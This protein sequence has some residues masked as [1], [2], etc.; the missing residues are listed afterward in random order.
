MCERVVVKLEERADQTFMTFKVLTGTFTF[1]F[2]LM[3][4]PSQTQNSFVDIAQYQYLS[5]KNVYIYISMTY[6]RLFFELEEKF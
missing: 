4:C 5:H 1:R 3:P 6:F 2:L